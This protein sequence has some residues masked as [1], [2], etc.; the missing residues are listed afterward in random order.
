VSPYIY[1]GTIHDLDAPILTIAPEPAPSKHFPRTSGCG[2]ATG[3]TAGYKRHQKAGEEACMPCKRAVAAYAQEYRAKV[4]NGYRYEPKGF[5]DEKCGTYAGYVQHLR[6]GIQS[7]ADCR[8][9]QAAYMATY[10]A[11]RKLVA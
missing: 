11:N 8:K 3:T 9:A 5:A 1:R 4:R 7:C 2:D 10:R 6:H